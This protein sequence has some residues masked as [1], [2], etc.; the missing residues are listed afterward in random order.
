MSG[1]LPLTAC[2]EWKALGAHHEQIR[3]QHLRMLF[4][5]DATNVERLTAEAVGVYLDY[6]K[7]RVTEK[8]VALLGRLAE[9]SGLSGTTA[10]RTT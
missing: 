4:A 5:D 6:S 1:M 7:N 9:G 8:T 2:P 10:R 3:G